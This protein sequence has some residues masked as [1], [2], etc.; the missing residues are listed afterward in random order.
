MFFRIWAVSCRLAPMEKTSKHDEEDGAGW[1]P[2]AAPVALDGGP[3]PGYGSGGLSQASVPSRSPDNF[4]CM[5]GPCKHYW[6]L[7]TMADEGNP[8]DTWKHLGIEPPRKHHHICLVNPG[9][10]TSFEDDNVFAC[11]KWDPL[12]LYDLI[13]IEGSREGYFKLHPE[14]KAQ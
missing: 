8:P 9:F 7:T 13:E 3:A 12:G 6:N 1:D 14:H 11:N 4:V 5:R 10:E 2:P